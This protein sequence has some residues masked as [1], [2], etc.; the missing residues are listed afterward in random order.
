MPYILHI[1]N[2]HNN[3]TQ[4]KFG[5]KGSLKVIQQTGFGFLAYHKDLHLPPE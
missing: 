1:Q 3:L 5:V 4:I 2:K